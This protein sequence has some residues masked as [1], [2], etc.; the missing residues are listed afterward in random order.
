M[1]HGDGLAASALYVDSLVVQE[2][3]SGRGVR[4]RE[5][6]AGRLESYSGHENGE[7]SGTDHGSSPAI[8]FLGSV[9]GTACHC[10]CDGVMD[11]PFCR[12]SDWDSV[13]RWFVLFSGDFWS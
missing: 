1:A 12:R 8:G 7:K 5:D 3:D 6:L 9:N 4:R 13:G 2:L 10:C 11:G